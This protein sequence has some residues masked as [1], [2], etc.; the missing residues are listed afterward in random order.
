M[1]RPMLLIL[2]WFAGTACAEAQALSVTAARM[3]EVE[4]GRVL[5]DHV[6][7]IDQGAIVAVAPRVV[8]QQVDIELG[9]VTLLPGLIDAH[10]HLAGGEEQTPVRGSHADGGARCDRGRCQRAQDAAGRLHHGA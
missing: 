7:K 8:G 9:D 4:T 6:I 2:M 3:L 1:M 10:V 5:R